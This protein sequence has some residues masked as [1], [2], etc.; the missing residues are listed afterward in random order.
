M[1]YMGVMALLLSRANLDL[2]ESKNSHKKSSKASLQ[3]IKNPRF[4]RLEIE[5]GRSKLCRERRS[6]GHQKELWSSL[7]Q[8]QGPVTAP[9][10]ATPPE[11]N[12]QQLRPGEWRTGYSDSD[13]YG[14]THLTN[15]RKWTKVRSQSFS[16]ELCN[17]SYEKN[18]SAQSVLA[19]WTLHPVM[20]FERNQGASR[21]SLKRR[22]GNKTSRRRRFRI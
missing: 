3:V 12:V 13:Y 21:K 16:T 5:E 10:P 15:D 8:G 7:S 4:K 19:P 22:F 1:I 18:F 11:T 2:H 9:A 14:G 20:G 17:L 6:A